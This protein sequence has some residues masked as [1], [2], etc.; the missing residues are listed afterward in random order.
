MSAVNR[1]ADSAS[2][3]AQR[4]LVQPTK[5]KITPADLNP[6]RRMRRQNEADHPAAASG[7]HQQQQKLYSE[8]P[9]RK[10]HP[11]TPAAN[12]TPADRQ[13]RRNAGTLPNLRAFSYESLI[14]LALFLYLVWSVAGWRSSD[15]S[16]FA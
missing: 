5:K 9:Q 8:W 12:A 6:E 1:T 3:T 11:A 16:Y 13:P 7:T 15:E 10:S 2:D 4:Y 14:I